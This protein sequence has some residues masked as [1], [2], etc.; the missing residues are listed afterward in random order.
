MTERSY[1]VISVIGL[2][3]VINAEFFYNEIFFNQSFTII[4]QLQEGASDFKIKAWGIFS[5][6]GLIC[7]SVLPIL[8]TLLFVHQRPRALYYGIVY[9]CLWFMNN[10]TKLNYHQ[11]RPYWVSS[12]VMI[13][14]SCHV[15]Y[16]NPSAHSSSTIMTLLILWLDYN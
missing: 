4:P 7:I 16:G 8:I 12:E 1:I 13:F 2:F 5:K 14:E 3:L 15:S 11:A 10:E 6:Y 9:G